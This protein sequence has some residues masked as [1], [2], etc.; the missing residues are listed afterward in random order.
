MKVRLVFTYWFFL[1]FLFSY[2]NTDKYRII[3]SD[4]PATSITIAWNQISGTNPLIYFDTTDYGTNHTL[5]NNSQ[6]V[7]RSVSYKSM[8][9]RFV[10]LTGL[11]PNT[12]YYFIIKDSQSTSQRFWFRT[13]PDDNSR[14]S[15]IA[16]GD[17]RNNR[18]PRQNA[19]LLVSKLKPHAVFFGG[20]MTDDDTDTEWQNWFDDWQ[21]TIANDGRMFPIIPAR[22]NHEDDADGVYKLFDT[23]NTDSYYA[24]TFGDDLIRAYTLN[25]EIS[26]LGNQLTWLQ[27]DLSTAPT[28]LKWKMAQ[29]HKPMRP[30]T[31]WKA[32]NNNQYS[33][34]AELFYTQG[35]RL[36]V[37][38]DSH[39]TKTTWP[40]KPSSEPNNDEGFEV[41]QTYG[42]VYTGEGCWGAPLRPNDDDKSWTRNSG[43]FNQFKLIFVD[44]S[45]I[46]LRTI[47]VNNASSVGSASNTNPFILPSQL[48][49]FN[50]PTG[51]VVTITNTQDT[52][53]TISNIFSN[54][55]IYSDN[56]NRLVILNGRI[57]LG[58]TFKLYDINGRLVTSNS[59]DDNLTY[60]TIDVIPYQSGIYI[61]ELTSNSD[62]KYSKKLIIR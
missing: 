15:F 6:A 52:L 39:M 19:N 55:N 30:H 2:A 54:I 34:W 4:N 58:T 8:E 33:A 50:P 31:A 16:G 28:A 24:I 18:L 13:A 32:E 43:S 36:V 20:D 7:D 38:C 1:G 29:Y 62:G 37:D 46:E 57:P 22:G 11:Q 21:L 47:R 49:V 41:D 26:V 25:T 12:N 51:D 45:K 40:V 10:R 60:Q 53:G 23:P 17:S 14:L 61:L 3:I 27:N 44:P 59:L 5:Y 42:T 9:N 35:V 48:D 56:D